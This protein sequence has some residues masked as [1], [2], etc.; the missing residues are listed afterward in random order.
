MTIVPGP[1]KKCMLAF[2]HQWMDDGFEALESI[3]IAEKNS[4]QRLAIDNTAGGRSGK[5]ASIS[6]TASPRLELVNDF[7]RN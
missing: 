6:S 5:A 1:F 2:A 7:R 3:G 4:R